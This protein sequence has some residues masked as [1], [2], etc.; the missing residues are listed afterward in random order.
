MA[1]RESDL[2]KLFDKYGLQIKST[3]D[4]LQVI[5]KADNRM[6]HTEILPIMGYIFLFSGIFLFVRDFMIED[7]LV[8]VLGCLLL[9][10]IGGWLILYYYRN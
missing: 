4:G 3:K 7:L 6:R 8:L 5:K 9:T 1:K 2:D 10:L